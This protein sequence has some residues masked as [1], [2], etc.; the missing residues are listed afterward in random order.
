MSQFAFT[1]LG[2]IPQLLIATLNDHTR[3]VI[4]IDNVLCFYRDE[5]VGTHPFNLPTELGNTI[6]MPLVADEIDGHDIRLI[7]A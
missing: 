4:V 6:E 3:P 7:V 2:R 1:P 5:W